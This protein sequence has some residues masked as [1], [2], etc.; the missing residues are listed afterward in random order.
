MEEHAEDIASQSTWYRSEH[1]QYLLTELE[2]DCDWE[3]NPITRKSWEAFG[4]VRDT[5]GSFGWSE[6]P[7]S[8]FEG[9]TARADT[10]RRVSALGCV[11]T[12]PNTPVG[13]VSEV[14]KIRNV[15]NGYSLV[16]E[17]ARWMTW[18]KLLRILLRR[19]G[20]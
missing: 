7:W 9:F 13:E 10:L 16:I 5:I 11:V 6:R 15:A 4:Q 8:D 1:I 18:N 20:I 12:V 19:D 3:N 2:F 14:A 17:I